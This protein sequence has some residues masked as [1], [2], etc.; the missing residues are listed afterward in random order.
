MRSKIRG[1]TAIRCCKN[2]DTFIVAWFWIIQPCQCISWGKVFPFVQSLNR[3][4]VLRIF[5]LNTGQDDH[6]IMLMDDYL[7]Q[8]LLCAYLGFLLLLLL[9]IFIVCLVCSIRI[10]VEFVLLLP[11]HESPMPLGTPLLI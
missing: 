1:L 10:F 8:V 2:F 7:N 3:E 6:A 5:K 11:N 9:L 4:K